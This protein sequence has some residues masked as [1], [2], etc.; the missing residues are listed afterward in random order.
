MKTNRWLIAVVVGLFFAVNLAVGQQQLPLFPKY[1]VLGV[2]YAPPGATSN[3]NYGNSTQVGSSHSIVSDSSTTT[4]QTQSNTS[5]FNLFGFGYSNTTTTSDSWTSA[6]QNSSSESLQTTSGNNII[7][8]GV[9]SSL[10]IVHDNDLIVLWLDPVYKTTLMPPVTSNG[11]TTY[12]IQWSGFMFNSCDLN[13]QTQYPVNFV[14]LIDGCDPISFPGPEIINVPVYCLKNPYYNNPVVNGCVGYLPYLSRFWDLNPWG[15]DTVTKVPLGPGLDVQD[16]ADILQADPLVTQTLVA[17]NTQAGENPYTNPCHPSYGLNFD[18]NMVETVKDS[19]TFTPPYVGTWPPNYCGTPTIPPGT[20]MQR[21]N[22]FTANI[23]YPKPINNQTQTSTGYLDS[24]AVTTLGSQSTDTH[25][26]S[27]NES[28]SLTFAA[29]V[30]YGPPTEDWG[31]VGSTNLSAGFNFGSTSGNG[32]SWSDSQTVGHTATT[33]QTHSAAYSVTGPASADNWTGPYL[34]NVYQDA[35]YGTFA[36]RD[37]DR[38]VSSQL[39]T[40]GKT[41]PIGVAFSG[42]TNF[43]TVQVGKHS[44]TI[45]VT[46]TN[47]SPNTMT[48]QSPSLSFSDLALNPDTT[49]GAVPWISS[50]VIVS[51]GCATK[52]LKAAATC[53]DTIEFAPTLNA[54]PNAEQTS[55]PVAAYV[56]AGGLETVPAAGT[57]EQPYNETILVTNTVI[58]LSGGTETATTVSGT[59]KPAAA[60]CTGIKPSCDLGATLLPATT[61][62]KPEQGQSAANTLTFKNYDSNSVTISSGAGNGVV[63]RGATTIDTAAYSVPTSTDLCTG[64]TVLPLTTCTVS[65]QYSPGSNAAGT[66]ANTQVSLMGVVTGS[67]NTPS[68]WADAGISTTLTGMLFDKGSYVASACDNEQTGSCTDDN[69]AIVTVTNNSN[70]TIKSIAA[71]IPGVGQYFSIYSGCSSLA[72]NSSCTI[73]VDYDQTCNPPTGQYRC[74]ISNTGSLV[75]TGTFTDSSL[76]ASSSAGITGRYTYVGCSNPN[77][78]E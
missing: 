74:T 14:Q 35:V 43:G 10:G 11:V 22:F 20:Q 66:T 13:V 53:K 19:S 61:T 12:P 60:T 68:T 6:Y 18:T 58:S 50:F 36:F 8:S 1:Q 41:S 48:M 62:N 34:Y 64:K 4:T 54:A 76:G 17:D 23:Q 3:V 37:S 69:P 5:G 67:G 38:S 47:N 33:G 44:A 9:Q 72:A 28:E 52:V 56:I 25:S 31:S 24:T 46:L 40:A 26:H 55:Y 71:T 32:S 70:T 49:P 7:V 42:S 21:F 45:T 15:T 30:S 2:I 75:V 78:C 59:A 39:I 77:R 65:I 27:F 51:D 16:L 29:E 63:L 73:E 57:G